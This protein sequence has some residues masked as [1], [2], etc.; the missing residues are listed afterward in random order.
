M[1]YQCISPK[2]RLCDIVRKSLGLY[3]AELQHLVQPHAGKPPLLGCLRMLIQ[4]ISSYRPYWSPF[5]HPQRTKAKGTKYYKC[6]V[7]LCLIY[8]ACNTNALRAG[9]CSVSRGQSWL[10]CIF[11]KIIL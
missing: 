3:S 4:Y 5:L 10:C 11:L 1:S 2:L 7:Y 9:V 6:K 8:P